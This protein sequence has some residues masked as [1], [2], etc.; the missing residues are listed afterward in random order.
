MFDFSFQTILF[1]YD[2]PFSLFMYEYCC[3]YTAESRYLEVD[4]TIF[5]KLKLPEVQINLHFG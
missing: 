2:F 4:G 3:Q 1:K 5:Y